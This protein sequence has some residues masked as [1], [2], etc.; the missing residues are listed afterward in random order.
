MKLSLSYELIV[1]LASAL[2]LRATFM[3]FTN[4]IGHDR[5]VMNRYGNGV[6]HPGTIEPFEFITS[7]EPPRCMGLVFNIMLCTSEYN[8]YSGSDSFLSF[9]MH[10][11]RINF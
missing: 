5:Y 2:R 8:R 3:V 10:A 1:P 11:A 7:N 6:Y 4:A 9:E